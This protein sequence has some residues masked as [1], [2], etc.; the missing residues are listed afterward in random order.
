LQYS[1]CSVE[2]RRRVGTGCALSGFIFIIYITITISQKNK[3]CVGVVDTK[4]SN[5]STHSLFFSLG[6]GEFKTNKTTTTTKTNK[7]ATIY[8]ISITKC[9]AALLKNLFIHNPTNDTLFYSR[10]VTLLNT[11]KLD[12]DEPPYKTTAL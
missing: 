10:A 8:Y 9:L 7:P 2:Y 6:F 11:H 4:S 1:D 5:Q 12:R 3:T